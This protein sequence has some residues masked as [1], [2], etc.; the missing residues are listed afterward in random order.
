M[1][2]SLKVDSIRHKNKLYQV[3]DFAIMFD[4][5]PSLSED[6]TIQELKAELWEEI[7]TRVK[8]HA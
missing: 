8:N 1:I 7:T 4:K 6:Y 2:K 5:S 3:S